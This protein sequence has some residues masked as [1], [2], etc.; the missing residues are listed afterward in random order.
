[1]C[2]YLHVCILS[3]HNPIDFVTES[4]PERSLFK[5][6]IQNTLCMTKALINRFRIVTSLAHDRCDD[7]FSY[8]ST[9]G[10]VPQ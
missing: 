2:V 7:V 10:N 9:Q 8:V 6:L 4:I 3:V 5:Q 1:M